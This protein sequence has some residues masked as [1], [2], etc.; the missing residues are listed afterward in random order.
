MSLS[1]PN[2]RTVGFAMRFTNLKRTKARGLGT[3]KIPGP[4][5]GHTCVGPW[6]WLVGCGREAWAFQSSI[7]TATG[8]PSEG[9]GPTTGHG[10]TSLLLGVGQGATSQPLSPV[11]AIHRKRGFGCS[12]LWA[13]AGSPSRWAKRSLNIPVPPRIQ[14]Y[15]VP[16][17]GRGREE[18]ERVR[19]R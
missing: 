7:P 15:T 13:P 17:R 18:A 3:K 14:I 10:T 12:S 16:E 19:E 9:A 5:R 6:L 8:D 11:T 2:T 1:R 4:S